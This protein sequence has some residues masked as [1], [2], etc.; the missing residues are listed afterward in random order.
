MIQIKL[1]WLHGS[2][3]EQ[4]KIRLVSSFCELAKQNGDYFLVP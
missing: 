3:I 4:N 1:R 2:V